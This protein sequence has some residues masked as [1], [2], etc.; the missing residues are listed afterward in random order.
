M[1]KRKQSGGRLVWSRAAQRAQAAGCSFGPPASTARVCPLRAPIAGD[2]GE[3]DSPQPEGTACADSYGGRNALYTRHLER[4]PPCCDQQWNRVATHPKAIVI[5]ALH[6]RFAVVIGTDLDDRQCA[7][8]PTSGQVA[9]P[10]H[11][12]SAL[13]CAEAAHPFRSLGAICASLGTEVCHVAVQARQVALRV[14]RAI[15]PFERVGDESA[16]RAATASLL[17][18]CGGS[19][20]GACHLGQAEGPGPARG[21]VAH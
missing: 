17:A 12:W 9:C 7:H 18:G 3:I 5:L 16:L 2:V 21:A 6:V 13:Q 11:R 4:P 19:C 10:A 8:G 1:A 15:P 14:P 20:I